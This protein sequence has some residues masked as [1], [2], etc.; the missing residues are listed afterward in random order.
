MTLIDLLCADFRSN[1]AQNSIGAFGEGREDDDFEE[2]LL[3]DAKEDSL[4]LK[5]EPAEDVD[6]RVDV[7]P[8][9]RG[10]WVLR[11]GGSEEHGR[12]DVE[13]E[14]GGLKIVGKGRFLRI[15]GGSMVAGWL[16]VL[17]VGRPG[18]DWPGA[19]SSSEPPP[20]T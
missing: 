4:D 8:W 2:K 9:W 20:H 6:D 5:E 18:E 7:D 10:R 15:V 11:L 13:E 3:E 19:G 16:H 1:W 17:A 12:L 14:G